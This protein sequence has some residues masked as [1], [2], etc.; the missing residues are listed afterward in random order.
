[1]VEGAQY[2]LWHLSLLNCLQLKR[3]F[4][5]TWHVWVAYSDP[6]TL[7]MALCCLNFPYSPDSTNYDKRENC[8]DPQTNTAARKQLRES[9]PVA[10]TCTGTSSPLQCV[11]RPLLHCLTKNFPNVTINQKTSSPLFQVTRMLLHFL[12]PQEFAFNQPKESITNAL[13]M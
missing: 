8:Q 3:I 10:V 9:P 1:M 4:M 5:P 2:F 7:L 11:P 13:N 12:P 6:H